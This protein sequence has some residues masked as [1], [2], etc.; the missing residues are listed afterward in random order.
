MGI[1]SLRRPELQAGFA[2]AFLTILFCLPRTVTFRGNVQSV[3][4][5]QLMAVRLE[6]Q[7][8]LA[9]VIVD[10]PPVNALSAGIP[11]A[12]ADS[13]ATA[14]ADPTVRAIVIMGAGPRQPQPPARMRPLPRATHRR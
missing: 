4:N 13:V 11:E 8:D 10:N 2:H 14:A 5:T 1:L 7:G 3:Y 6:P 12:L 9:F